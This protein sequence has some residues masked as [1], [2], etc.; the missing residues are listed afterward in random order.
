MIWGKTD[1]VWLVTFQPSGVSAG[2][3]LTGHAPVAAA[4]E[5][6]AAAVAGPPLVPPV[7]PEQAAARRAK[8]HTAE[9]RIDR[10]MAEA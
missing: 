8:A 4:P 3:G 7:P 10:V 5:A 2:V 1:G 9:R 6:E